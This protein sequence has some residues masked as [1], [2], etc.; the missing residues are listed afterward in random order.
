MIL[1]IFCLYLRFT[2]YNPF[3]MSKKTLYLLGIV[4]TILIGTW[5]FW[6]YCC[7]NL[8]NVKTPIVATNTQSND[9][10]G[11]LNS[12]STDIETASVN[13]SS[14]IQSGKKLLTIYFSTGKTSIR[15]NDEDKANIDSIKK[16]MDEKSDVNLLLTGYSDNTG[17]DAI[18]EIVSQNRADAVKTKLVS[19]GLDESRMGTAAKGSQ[20]PI[21]DNSTAEGRTQNRRVEV[22]VK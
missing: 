22:T 16:L 12:D 7:P 14:A 18:N 11:S 13:D 3:I 1:V 8:C 4:V 5:L 6:K 19:M 9:A 15:L 2:N 17:T 20:N 10:A 21:A